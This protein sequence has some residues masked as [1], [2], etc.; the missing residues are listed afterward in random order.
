MTLEVIES[1]RLSNF[2]HPR[3]TYRLVGHEE[4]EAA[5]IEAWRS[6]RL[7]HAWLITGPYGIGK[8]TF[9]YRA[10]RALL[11]HGGEPPEQGAPLVVEPDAPAARRIEQQ[12]HLNLLVL[13]RPYD[14]T[15]KKP[16]T[17]LTVDEVRRIASFFGMSA[18]EGGWRIC[19]VDTADDMNAAAANAFL[20]T[21]EEPPEKSLLLVL[22]NVP[23][24]VLPT[25]RSRCRRL[26]LSPLDE[27]EI[28]TLLATHTPELDPAD[29][30]KLAEL[31]Q[32]SI[33]RALT[34]AR[35]NGLKARENILNV[36]ETL[37]ELDDLALINLSNSMVRRGMEEVYSFT[38][39]FLA[40]HVK[41][42]IRDAARETAAQQGIGSLD[43]YIAPA[44]FD[45]WI[46]V[47]ENLL[48]LQKTADALN[49]DRKQTLMQAFFYIR[50]AC[51]EKH[52]T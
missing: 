36:L 38:M 20:K 44:S 49:L 14:R 3:E 41:R 52:P 16:K 24:T 35:N 51:S 2:P 43:R 45:R 26:A 32:G 1:D 34:L 46:G 4:A 39:A 6:G 37:P 27:E 28:K 13:K 40:D 33:G 50:D 42:H 17:V 47:W 10:A 31:S 12:S 9:A 11:H 21:L 18:G 29:R 23:G 15:R 19:I 8:A 22:A 5:F 7:P 30:Q 25:I 48:R